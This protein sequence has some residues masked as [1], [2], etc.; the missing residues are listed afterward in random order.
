M[1]DAYVAGLDTAPAP[2][3]TSA[4]LIAKL[5][6]AQTVVDAAR[7]FDADDSFENMETLKKAIE[8]YK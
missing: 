7:A 8:A 3:E 2:P 4:D 1:R 5:A 6:T